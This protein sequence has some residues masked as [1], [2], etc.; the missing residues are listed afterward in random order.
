MQTLDSFR[1]EELFETVPSWLSEAFERMPTDRY[2][3]LGYRSRRLSRFHVNE[4]QIEP[5]PHAAY[6]QDGERGY[7][8]LLGNVERWFEEIEPTIV[9]SVGFRAL[10]LRFIALCGVGGTEISVNVHL[11]RN[12]CKTGQPGFPA[13]E[14]VHRDG[15][16]W[17]GIL[18][19]ALHNVIGAETTLYRST[20]TTPPRLRFREGPRVFAMLSS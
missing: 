8:T 5:L 10:V 13:P 6:V 16:D 11:I 7:N 19:V 14:G 3:P 4:N 12:A 20:N 18:C 9:G 1:L 17:V 2:I 15:F